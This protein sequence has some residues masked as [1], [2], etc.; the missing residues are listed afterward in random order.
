MKG[1]MIYQEYTANQNYKFEVYDC[2]SLYEVWLQKRIT[3]DY[4]GTD[5]F[6]YH[7]ISDYMHYADSLDRAIE[8]GRECLRSL[9]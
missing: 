4:M 6:D 2:Q 7:P 8:I 9:L 3:D 5:W 1:T